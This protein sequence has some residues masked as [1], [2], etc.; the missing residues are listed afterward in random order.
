MQ[1]LANASVGTYGH[2]F[3]VRSYS[4]DG[5]DIVIEATEF[6]M[7]MMGLSMDKLAIVGQY[8]SLDYE[9]NEYGDNYRLLVRVDG[10][11]AKRFGLEIMSEARAV[12]IGEAYSREEDEMAPYNGRYWE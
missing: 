2:W 12:G 9:N 11:W 1:V 5:S 7:Y 10:A 8:E 4:A 3:D 6:E